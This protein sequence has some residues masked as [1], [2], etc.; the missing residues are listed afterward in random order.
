MDE[1]TFRKLLMKHREELARYVSRQLPVKVGAKAQSI[2]RENFRLGGFQDKSLVKWAVTK[3]QTSGSGTDSQRGPLLSSRKVLYDGTRY[4]TGSG[5]VTVY[6]NVPYAAVHNNGGV[7][8][9]HVTPKMRRYA[10][11]RHYNA[12]SKDSP[13]AK[14]WKGL[15]LTRKRALNIRIPQRKFIGPGKTLDT[16]IRK[17]VEKDLKD[18]LKI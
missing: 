13:E 18:I 11:Y 3:R 16:A 4:S 12:G 15:A 17:I 5:S 10:W 7:T 6:N 9:P 14:M 1:R 2:V 8:H